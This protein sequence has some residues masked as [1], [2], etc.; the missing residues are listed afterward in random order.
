MVVPEAPGELWLDLTLEHDHLVASN[1]YT[2]RI[3]A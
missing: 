3:T 1:R 2:C